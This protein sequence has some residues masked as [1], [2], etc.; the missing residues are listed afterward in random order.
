V[1]RLAGVPGLTSPIVVCSAA[2]SHLVS[3]ELADIGVRLILEP[4]GRNT[5][6][7]VAAV[8]LALADA[9]SILL[10]LPADHSIKDD[11]AFKAG[12]LAGADLAA[13]GKLVA[14]GVLPTYAETGYGYIKAGDPL[15]GQAFVVDSFVEK[16]DADTA[17]RYVDS[18]GYS[19]N[20]GMFMFAADRFLEELATH[21][22]EILSAVSEAVGGQVLTDVLALDPVA[23]G[24][25]PSDSIDFA[26]MEHTRAAA[27]IP[28]DAGWS[29]I[30]SW[31]ALWE[32][33]TP[34]DSLNV[35]RGD[36][37]T[38]GSRGSLVWAEHRLV[39]TVDV[40]NIVVVETADA[41]LVARRDRTQ[42]VAGLVQDL[43]DQHRP[44]AVSHTRERR[45]WG[46]F[47]VLAGGD[48]YQVK[49]LEV[50]PGAK[51]S[52]QSHRHRAEEWTVVNG[53]ARVTLDDAELTI[54][55]GGSVSVPIEG[56]HRLAN[57]GKI[58]LVVIEVQLG[59]Y[60]GEDD[61]VRYADDY[62]RS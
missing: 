39:T 46:S 6:P 62:G 16:P 20:S 45:P 34:D 32:L 40:E 10:V 8:A 2:H 25:S 52:L 48:R 30:G 7:A 50:N 42:N 17:A 61:I 41:V 58:P 55:E 49:R 27:V 53:T 35:H 57:P 4:V 28:L 44:E 5:A 56:K 29:D 19:W 14:F 23:F 18:G 15:D 51:L 22:P 33:S 38:R 54:T 37:I 13:A 1:Q 31:S 24:R 9:D 3:A 12:V 21:E 36:V 26:V 60:L 59:S 11:A 43:L 47:E